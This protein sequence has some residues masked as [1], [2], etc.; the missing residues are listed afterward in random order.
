[1]MKAAFVTTFYHSLPIW[2]DGDGQD[3]I[4]C[5]ARIGAVPVEGVDTNILY[6]E[7]PDDVI[8]EMEAHPDYVR[9]FLPEVTD[10]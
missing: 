2:P 9:L 10:V 8:A 5:A 1:M 4:T 3:R 7:A 6:I